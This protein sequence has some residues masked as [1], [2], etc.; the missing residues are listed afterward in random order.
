M[1]PLYLILIVVLVAAASL[2]VAQV[3]QIDVTPVM[4]S[5][6]QSRWTELGTLTGP[7]DLP[8]VSDR[9][10]TTVAVLPDANTITWELDNW[11]RKAMLSFQTDAE[12]DST[13]VVILAFADN[14]SYTSDGALTLDDDAVYGGQ[15]VLTGGQ[16]VGKHSN[17]YVDTIVATDGVFSFAVLDSAVNHRCIVKFNTDG[18]KK[19]VIIATTLQASSTLYAEG[20]LFQ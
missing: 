14:K 18:F 2:C 11:G 6:P 8:G 10:Y 20:R 7:N 17:V 16:Q 13:T 12:A 1:K 3:S 19:I 4:L 9:D 15:L 5:S